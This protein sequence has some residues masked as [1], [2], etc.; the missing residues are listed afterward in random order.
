MTVIRLADSEVFTT[1]SSEYEVLIEAAKSIRGV[2]GAV[3]EIGS[4]QGGSAK[5][6]IDALEQNGDANRPMFCIDPYG[7]IDVLCTNLNLSEHYPDVKLEGDPKS[8][9]IVAPIKPGFTNAMRNWCVP[10]L[11]YCA[12]KAG[13]NFTFFCL[14]DTEFF[15][16][17]ADGVPVYDEVK[18]IVNEY[19]LVFFDGPHDNP[20]V[21]AETQFFIDRSVLGTVFVYDDVWMYDHARIEEML[22]ASGFRVKE[23]KNVKA[24][25]MRIK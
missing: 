8:T 21:V 23:K 24:S 7:N 9:D 16:R 6:I 14:E 1:D 20:S 4:R 17:Y 3:V 10:S 25:Y 11:Y 2:P 13:L 12:Y 5:M 22:L 18:R 19:A 15:A